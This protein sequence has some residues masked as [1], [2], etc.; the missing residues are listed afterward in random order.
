MC[1]LLDAAELAGDAAFPQPMPRAIDTSRRLERRARAHGT[2]V[3]RGTLATTLGIT[4]SDRLGARL[5]SQRARSRENLE[6]IAVALACRDRGVPFAAVLGVT[7]RVG[8]RVARNGLEHRALAASTTAEL[9]L[10]WLDAGAPGV[11]ATSGRQADSLTPERYNR[12]SITRARSAN[13]F[14]ARSS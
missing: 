2:D 3:L 13:V 4:T 5:A 11:A 1:E 6:A 7:N 14:T 8:R 10:R 12:R 9:V